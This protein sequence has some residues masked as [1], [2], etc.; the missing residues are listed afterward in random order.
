MLDMSEYANTADVAG[1]WAPIILLTL[2]IALILLVQ[3]RQS[4]DAQSLGLQV[5]MRYDVFES[6]EVG[7]SPNG[8]GH[9]S[10]NYNLLMR[11][12]VAPFS[13]LVSDVTLGTSSTADQFGS[14]DNRSLGINLY[15]RQPSY[16]LISR[17]NRND[18]RSESLGQDGASIGNSSNHNVGLLLSEPAYPVLNLQYSR[19]ASGS[20]FGDSESRYA[21][22]TWLLGSYYDLSPFRFTF[23]QSKQTSVYSGSP[24]NTQTTRRSSVLLNQTLLQGLTLV[25]ELSNYATDNERVGARSSLDTKRQVLRLQ[26][27]PTSAVAASLEYSDQSSR[28]GAV[29]ASNHSGENALSFNVR[30]Q[31]LPGLSA[32]FTGQRQRLSVT[33]GLGG[34]I[35]VNSANRNLGVSARLNDRSILNGSISRS[36]YAGAGGSGSSQSSFQVSVQSRLSRTADLSLDYGR[37]KSMIGLDGSFSGTFAGVSLRTRTSGGMSMG[38]SYRRSQTDS[39]TADASPISQTTDAVD[40]DALWMPTYQLSLNLRLSYQA[41]NG[42]SISETLSPA[43]GVRWQI[44]PSTNLSLNYN[45]QSDKQWDWIKWE[46]IGQRRRGSVLR[47]SHAFPDRSSL[48]F[49]YDFHGGNTGLIEWQRH[50]ALYYSAYL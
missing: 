13:A 7:E 40:F 46:F 39:S 25:G 5:Q 28:L 33:D 11:G 34:I 32:D 15:Y 23:D 29:A 19:I 45:Y 8:D 4:A 36:D 27:I 50:I 48:E 49:Y 47:L 10:T 17:I 35:F 41:N 30:A 38:A 16:T 26:A 20:S 14:Q 6:R 21:A 1:Y 2:L 22:N 42:S 12:P 24:G 31:V 44:A 37:N 18:Y 43:L 3:S 9:L